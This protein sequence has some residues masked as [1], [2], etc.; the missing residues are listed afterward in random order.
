MLGRHPPVSPLFQFLYLT[1]HLDAN[2]RRYLWLS[3]RKVI[4]RGL[5][6]RSYRVNKNLEKQLQKLGRNQEGLRCRRPQPK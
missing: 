3:S 5:A 4:Y 6:G 2:D 1:E